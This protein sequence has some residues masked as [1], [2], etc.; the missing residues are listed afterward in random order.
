MNPTNIEWTDRTVNPVVGCTHGCIYCYARR[1]A[2]RPGKESCCYDFIPHPHLERLD[3]IKP[4]QKPLKIFIDS[5][6]D[7]NCKDNKEKWLKKIIKKFHECPQHTFQILSKRPKGYARFKFPSNVWLGTSITSNDDVR[8]LDRLV[9]SNKG[10]IKFVSI[11]PIHGKI[12]H[13]FSGIDWIIIGAETGNRREKIVPKKSWIRNII[14]RARKKQIP[15]FI[16]NNANWPEE[17]QEFP[18]TKNWIP[19]LFIKRRS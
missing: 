19:P 15:L 3:E 17:I 9:R 14:S 5:M 16:K 10:N 1:S 18:R 12:D 7:W 4:T 8:R 6:W 2:T 11:E 13:D